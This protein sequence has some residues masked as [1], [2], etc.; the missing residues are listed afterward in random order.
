MPEVRYLQITAA[1][2]FLASRRSV[3]GRAVLGLDFD[4]GFFGGPWPWP[5]AL[6]P[7]LHL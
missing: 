5:R 3:L 4:L 1:V 7:R 2:L 6:F